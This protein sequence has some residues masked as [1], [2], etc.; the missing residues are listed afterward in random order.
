MMAVSPALQRKA[1]DELDTVIG[2]SRLPTID[3]ISD[4][5]YFRAILME[6]LRWSPVA[7]LGTA[8]RTINDDEYNGYFIPAGTTVYGVRS[9]S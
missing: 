7:P 3:D 2:L 5:P 9:I 8:H 1:Q 6:V 4:L